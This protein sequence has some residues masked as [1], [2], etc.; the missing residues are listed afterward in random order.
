MTGFALSMVLAAASAPSATANVEI[1]KVTCQTSP[2]AASSEARRM[3]RTAKQTQSQI[4]T[5][6]KAKPGENAF[7]IRLVVIAPKK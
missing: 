5:A 7:N 3:C 2:G 6:S 1:F 4:D